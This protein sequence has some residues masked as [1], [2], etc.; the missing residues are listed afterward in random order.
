MELERQRDELF[1]DI[2]PMTLPKQECRWKKEPQRSMVEPVADGQ[3]VMP[4]G[5]TVPSTVP[6]G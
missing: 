5:Q 1:N 2:K 6:S 4:S 3:I